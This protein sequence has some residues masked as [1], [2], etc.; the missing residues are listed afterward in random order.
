MFSIVVSV[1]L[2]ALVAAGVEKV[3]SRAGGRLDASLTA[4][5]IPFLQEGEDVNQ[6][7]KWGENVL[8]HIQQA[9]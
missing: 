2:S 1:F 8:P 7:V 9:A 4:V 5:G 3:R 6:Q